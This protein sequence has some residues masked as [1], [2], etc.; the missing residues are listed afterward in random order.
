METKGGGYTFL[1]LIT[2]SVT[3]AE[4]KTGKVSRTGRVSARVANAGCNHR[5]GMGE[6]AAAAAI[7]K[8]FFLAGS[9]WSSGQEWLPGRPFV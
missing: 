6:V 5:T 4:P 3:P 2:A 7:T 1:P 9:Q 8:S